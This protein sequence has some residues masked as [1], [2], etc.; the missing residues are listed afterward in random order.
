MKTELTYQE[1]HKAED[2]DMSPSVITKTQRHKV[3]KNIKKKWTTQSKGSNWDVWNILQQK[4]THSNWV[5]RN[6]K[7]DHTMDPKAT[8]KKMS[9]K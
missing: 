7:I 4:N 8:L 1:I 5:L 6:I 2:F 9:K 3:S